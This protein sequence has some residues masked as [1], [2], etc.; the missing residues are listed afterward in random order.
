M[1]PSF[2]SPGLLASNRK[3]GENGKFGEGA[4]EKNEVGD[5]QEQVQAKKEAV[6]RALERGGHSST[7]RGIV[8]SSLL[9]DPGAVCRELVCY[10]LRLGTWKE[11]T[12]VSLLALGNE[13][14]SL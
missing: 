3:V 6:G 1:R 5:N 7:A 2:P 9:G 4:F 13:P 11:G 12:A 8:D 10:L 14:G